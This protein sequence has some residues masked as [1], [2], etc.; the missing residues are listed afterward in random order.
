[1][2]KAAFELLRDSGRILLEGA[3]KDLNLD[4]VQQ[5]LKSTAHVHDVHDLHVW[6]VTSNLPALSA[7]V[8]VESC[9][10]DG[11]VPQML[12]QLQDCVAGHFNVEHSTFQLE[13]AIHA[14]H[15]PG[16]H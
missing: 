12:D 14:S 15:E 4:Q 9:F 11:H 6:T 2:A 3:P 16:T 7:H 5:H 13:T 10:H 8:V 1:M